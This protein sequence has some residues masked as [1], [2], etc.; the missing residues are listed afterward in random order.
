MVEWAAEYQKLHPK[1]MIEISAG[2]AG[3]GMTDALSG[4]VDIGMISRAISPAEIAKGAFFV[5]VAEGAVVGTIN[6]G[7]PLLS[8]ILKRGLTR[9]MLYNIF[10]AQNVTSW[11]QALGQ[12]N[13]AQYPIHVYTR[14]DAAGAADS[15]AMYIGG[16]GQGDLK[17]IGVYA[18]PGIVQAVKSDSLGIGYNNIAYAYDNSTLQPIS[19]ISVLPVDMKGNGQIDPEENFYS[20]RTALVQAVQKGEYMTPPQILYLATKGTF[21]GVTKQ[22]VKWIL[23][24]GQSFVPE[25]GYIALT[26]NTINAQLAK[27][28]S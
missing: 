1:V 21:T 23:T 24:D 2:G 7:N 19:G 16:K 22:F 12:A 15:W 10:I 8:V 3:K 14:S 17:G 28:G 13:A 5:A 26:Q 25:A 11:E 9:Q 18:D 20:N 6:S 4:L 27:L